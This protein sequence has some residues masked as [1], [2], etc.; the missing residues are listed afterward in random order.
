MIPNRNTKDGS[1]IDVGWVLGSC[2]KGAEGFDCG[3]NERIIL[4]AAVFDDGVFCMM[5]HLG[6]IAYGGVCCFNGGINSYHGLDAS[7]V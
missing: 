2:V 6:C 7:F 3:G 4:G 1:S 5:G